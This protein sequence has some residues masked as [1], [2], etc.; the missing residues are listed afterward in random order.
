MSVCVW[1]CVRDENASETIV[2]NATDSIEQKQEM[3]KRYTPPPS[4]L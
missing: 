2:W 4:P 1:E 3:C